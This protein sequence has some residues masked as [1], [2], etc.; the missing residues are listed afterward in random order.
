[1]EKIY[2]YLRRSGAI[3]GPVDYQ[4]IINRYS[5]YK[6][7][8]YADAYKMLCEEGINYYRDSRVN[9][10]VKVA[11][12]NIDA[13]TAP[14]KD[15]NK[16]C[17]TVNTRSYK[18]TLE[19]LRYI[20]PIEEQL[21]IMTDRGYP[22][23]AK[24]KNFK[25]RAHEIFMIYHSIPNC[26]V[27]SLDLTG[28]DMHITKSMLKEEFRIY[29]KLYGDT[30]EIRRLTSAMLVNRITTEHGLRYKINGQRMSG[31]ATTS[32]G[33]VIQM[34]SILRVAMS[35]F[36]RCRSD[37]SEINYRFYD[38][39]D[40]CLLFVDRAY[41]KELVPHLVTVYNR[42]NH[43]L[44]VE[45]IAYKYEDI[46]FC[47]QTPYFNENTCQFEMVPDPWKVLS[48][49][50]SH[51]KYYNDKVYGRK[52]FKTIMF[53][54]FV[55]YNH[56]PVI[57]DYALKFLRL[58]DDIKV[59]ILDNVQ[60][61]DNEFHYWFKT[62]GVDFKS[63]DE[64]VKAYSNRIVSKELQTILALKYSFDDVAQSN[65]L[66]QIDAMDKRSISFRFKKSEPGYYARVK[67]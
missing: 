47:Q 8:R 24:G 38:D 18:F 5:G 25:V 19:L 56:M 21:M 22:C 31:D 36:N 51:Y 35:E 42:Y 14:G 30:P 15:H 39:G 46:V 63:Y 16:L 59:P 45:N 7:K 55:I 11:K 61:N 48:S 26:A 1:M 32:A 49:M 67:Y 4:D 44:K 6:K 65:L 2:D 53:G 17:R 58:L 54:Y 20:H 57:A 60:E 40:D 9:T 52:M 23:V 66:E 27:L 33:N 64:Y 41:V 10:F 50:T 43:V 3:C 13:K 37:K 28:F 34:I 62:E 12:F 29:R